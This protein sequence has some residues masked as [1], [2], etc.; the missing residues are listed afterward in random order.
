MALLLIAALM[1]AVSG[2]PGLVR[3]G[4]AVRRGA[5]ADRE[6]DITG[7]NLATTLLL[8]GVLVA[9][10]AVAAGWIRP[11]NEAVNLPWAVP[12]GLFELRLDALSSVF[13]VPVLLVAGAGAMYGPGYRPARA[14]ARN[15]A[16]FRFFYG[17]A[18]GAL[19]VLLTARGTL[20]FLAA[21]E[22]AA[23]CGF[24]L[25]STEDDQQDA[26]RAGYLYL[27]ATHTATL[28]LFG[29]FALLGGGGPWLRFP[30]AGTLPAGGAASAVFALGLFGFGLKA[31]IVPLHVWLPSAHAAA[32]T[33]ASALLSGVMIKTGIYGLVRLLSFYAEI[34]AWWGWTLLGLGAVSA[35]AG[36][37]LA[38]AQHDIKR[39]LAYHSVENIGIIVMGLGL[40]ALG[41]AHDLPALVALG[42]GGALLHTINHGLFKALL[43]LAA[44]SAVRT[45]GTREIE[46]MG[47]LLRRQRWTAAFFLTGAVAICGLP[48][49]NGFVSE[50]LVYRAALSAAGGAVHGTALAVMAAPVLALV[51]G[52]ALACFVKVFGV[53]F[54]GSPRGGAD[55]IRVVDDAE[56]TR[57]MRLGMGLLAAGCVVIGLFPSAMGPLLVAATGDWASAGPAGAPPAELAAVLG[58]AARLS[59][60]AALL[61]V[62]SAAV[63]LW[64]RRRARHAVYGAPT[65]SCGLEAPAPRARYT[66]SSFADGLVD[67]LAPGRRLER[68]ASADL[69][70]APARMHSHLPDIALDRVLVPA[71]R[72]VARGFVG[73]RVL[74]HNGR[75][76]AYLLYTALTLLVLLI[77]YGGK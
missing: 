39:L 22:I 28:A 36:V 49:L 34:P 17:L 66:A 48:P 32:P 1:M 75:T 63:A 71:Y 77:V 24:F 13:I 16:G 40:A 4:S 2:V 65:W 31:G 6:G 14:R 57:G 69:F 20:L 62:L 33:H 9:L 25:V 72:L 64:L 59:A 46:R 42:L 58:Q 74:L 45:V 68:A 47:G 37:A 44:G 54:L 35:V 11:G 52:L 10:V 70:P 55:D 41:R 15:A 56:A 43:F 3:S 73:M 27:T 19:I 76:H 12:G 67:V 23:L 21:W 5:A 51:G 18:V 60:A 29:M 30:E 26:R 7:A 38:L 53:M 8:T 50:W 61:L